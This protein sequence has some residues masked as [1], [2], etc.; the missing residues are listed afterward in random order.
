MRTVF[1]LLSLAAAAAAQNYT[2]RQITEQG[3]TIVR[4][5]DA[6]HAVEVSVMP[7]AGN[8]AYEMKVHGHNILYFRRCRSGAIRE[9]PAQW[10]ACRSWRLGA[11]G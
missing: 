11:T 5:S 8:R 6:A 4:L 10:K 2:A 7:S 1:L 9:A 3:V